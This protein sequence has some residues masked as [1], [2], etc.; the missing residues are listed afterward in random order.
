MER[1][2]TAAQPAPMATLHSHDA[3]AGH[4][5]QGPLW[6]TLAD[7]CGL[8]QMRSISPASDRVLF[9]HMQ[10]RPGQRIHRIG[11][12]FDTLYVVHAGFLKTALVDEFGNEQVL[13]FPMKGDM[14]GMDGIHVREHTSETLALSECDLILLPFNR[15]NSLSRVNPDIENLMYHMMSRELALRQAVIST[16]GTPSAEARVARFLIALSERFAAMGY[17]SKIFNLRMTRQEIGS[18]LGLT[19]ETVSRTMSALNDMGC[20]GVDQRTISVRDAQVLK[21]LC[22]LPP[23]H[24]RAR[25]AGEAKERQAPRRSSTGLSPKPSASR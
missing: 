9:Q 12:P 14:L 25:L 8:L 22:R 17:S 16:L 2:P 13:A 23:S 21:T 7:I 4:Q 24:A 3:K 10:F 6:S 15:L 1:Q 5:C 18:Y 19:L 20:I 11:Q